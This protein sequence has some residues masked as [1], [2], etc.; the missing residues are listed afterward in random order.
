MPSVMLATIDP[1]NHTTSKS[2]DDVG[3]VNA[4][5]DGRNISK[6]YSYDEFGRL[7]SVVN[8][9]SETTR[10]TYDLNGNM[11]TQTDGNGNTITYEYNA[12][13][14]LSKRIDHGGKT[15][16]TYIKAKT[17][18]YTYYPDGNIKSK[19]DRNGVKT[20]YTYDIFGRLLSVKAGSDIIRYTY[21]NNGNQLTMTDS[22]G[23]TTRTYDEQDRVSSKEVPVIGLSS[24]TYDGLESDGKYSETTT[25]SKGN[26]V[27]KVFDKAGRLVNVIADD[28]TTTYT[29]YADGSRKAVIYG[30]GAREDYT[31]FADGLSRH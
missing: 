13:N 19:T 30:S 14:K 7:V 22:T 15:G 21:D 17:E 9:K 29:Y 28:D 11:L 8:A 1:E 26:V 25:D 2:Y 23:T 4:E 20:D 5:T 16:T 27:K 31:Y 3:N 24:Y 18:T 12:A 10:Y 6:T